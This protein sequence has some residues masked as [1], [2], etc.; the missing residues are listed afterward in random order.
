[1]NQLMVQLF[2]LKAQI[3]TLKHHL[4]QKHHTPPVVQVY[5]QV[6]L[7]RLQGMA[8]TSSLPALPTAGLSVVLIPPLQQIT[9]AA[10]TIRDC[11]HE[12]ES[13]PA[14]VAHP[15]TGAAH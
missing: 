1:Y 5:L 8:D 14:A 15:H 11:L 10:A 2:I 4:G 12:I 6:A 9:T 7:D 13:A 3:T